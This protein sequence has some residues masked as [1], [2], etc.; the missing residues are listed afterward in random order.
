MQRLTKEQAAIIGAF[1]GI[2]VGN[3][4]DM[5]QYIEKVMGRSVETMEMTGEGFCKE[6]KEKVKPDLMKIINQ[7][8]PEINSDE[9]IIW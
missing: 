1:T 5:H 2:L 6:L 3:F 4:S 8:K 7:D 9:E